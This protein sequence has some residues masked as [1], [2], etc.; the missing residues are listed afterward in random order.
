MT[1]IT[2]RKP[3][4]V[5]TAEN[6]RPYIEIPAA[7]VGEVSALLRANTIPHAVEEIAISLDGGPETTVIN[8]GRWVDAAAVQRLLDDHH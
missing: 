8:L 1:D 3:L 2:T 7:Q 5:S 4:R 6:A